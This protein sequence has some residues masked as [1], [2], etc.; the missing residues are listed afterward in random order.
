[1]MRASV[2]QEREQPVCPTLAFLFVKN[3]KCLKIMSVKGTEKA[4]GN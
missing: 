3:A 2:D 4:E 1:M